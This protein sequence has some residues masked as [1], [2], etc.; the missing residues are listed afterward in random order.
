MTTLDLSQIASNARQR[1]IRLGRR[2]GSDDTFQQATK[3][4][5][6]LTTHGNDLLERGFGSADVSRLQ[7]A[8]SA[9]GAAGIGRETKVTAKKSTRKDYV[10]AL[11][12]AKTARNKARTILENILVL[13]HDEG[14]EGIAHHVES[15]LGQTNSLPVPGQDEALA[16]QL[17]LLAATLTDA[18]VANAAGPRGGQK[19]LVQLQDTASALRN[20]SEER[21]NTGTRMST[22]EMD[23]LDGIIVTLCRSARNAAKQ[24]SRELGRPAL[25]ADFALTHI[26]PARE[27]ESTTPEAT[28]PTPEATTL[29]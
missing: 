4:L 3:T 16:V 14:N 7:A 6:A 17:D 12:N 29:P 9:L 18:H 23:L 22:E 8:Q 19:A 2:Y 26:T 11:A 15:A 24:A 28:S 5:K 25:L 10:A 13:L 21:E 1:Y 27:H 20:D